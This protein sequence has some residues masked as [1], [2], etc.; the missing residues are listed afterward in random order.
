MAERVERPPS[1]WAVLGVLVAPFVIWLIA[2][3]AVLIWVAQHLGWWT[4]PL[5][6][7]TSILGVIVLSRY[8]SR[9]LRRYFQSATTGI[10]L[11]QRGSDT[12]MVIFGSFLLILPGFLSDA[13]GVLMVTPFTRPLLRGAYNAIASWTKRRN[14]ARRAE[15]SGIIPGEVVEQPQSASENHDDGP[16]VI[17]GTV[18][19]DDDEASQ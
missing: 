5:L 14:A 18:V 13:V 6:I 8:G 1:P 16:L 11:Q 17:E 12:G 4:L 15:A 3:V 10:P 2:E 19:E 9:A 7:A